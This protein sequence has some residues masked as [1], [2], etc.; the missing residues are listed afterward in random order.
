MKKEAIFVNKILLLFLYAQPFLDVLTSLQKHYLNDFLTIGVLVRIFFLII[1]GILFLLHTKKKKDYIYLI[2]YGIYL[3]IYSYITI[4]HKSA[5]ILPIELKNAFHILYLPVLYYFLKKLS[6]DKI[7]EKHFIRIYFIYLIFLIVPRIT[8]TSFEGYFEGKIGNIGWFYATNEISAILCILMPFV[9]SYLIHSQ[10]KLIIKIPY[11]V[12]MLYALL[13]LGTKMTVLIFGILFL[14]YLLGYVKKCYQE[15][16]KKELSLLSIMTITGLILTALLLPKTSFFYNIKIHLDFLDIHNISDVL[17][18][19]RFVN[20]FIFSERLTF[21]KNTHKNYQKA[22]WSEKLFGIG[23]IENYN[24]SDQ[25]EKTIEM[26]YFD[27]FYRTGI[28]GSALV[29]FPFLQK[30]K[31]KKKDNHTYGICIALFIAG[32]AGHVLTSPAVSIYLV[33]LL[34]NKNKELSN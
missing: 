16:K 9:F 29:I 3:I 6:L 20:H 10:E 8:H 22:P 14:S 4:T 34:L 19:D 28:I 24:Q 23:Y 5:S 27:I 1:I 11:F 26:D 2:F 31:K 7:E 13:A 18:N 17:K 25:N 33:T 12:M 15:K 32:V 30:I 21:L